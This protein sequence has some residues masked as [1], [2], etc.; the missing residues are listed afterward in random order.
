M[1]RVIYATNVSVDGFIED[2]NGSINFSTPDPDVFQAHTD[3]VRSC[4][5]YLYGRRLYESMAVWE[6]DPALAGQSDAT[7]AFAKAWQDADKIVYSTTLSEPTTARTRIERTFD[8]AAVA[9]LKA[10]TADDILIG[11]ADLAA[12]LIRA[13]LVDECRLYV[14][15]VIL[16]GGKPALPTGARVDLELLDVHQFGTGVLRVSYRT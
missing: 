7:G 10:A 9:D 12:Q 6:T 11:G 5:T 16:G 15:P 8:A 2:E 1:G 4:G 13:G 3:L 14:C